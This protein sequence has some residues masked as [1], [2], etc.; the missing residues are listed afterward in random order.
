VV[1][2]DHDDPQA[3]AVR[4]GDGGGRLRA[5][6]VD[7]ADHPGEHQLPLQGLLGGR[8][9]GGLEGPVGDGQGA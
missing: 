3:G 5:G 6:R 9:L 1:A 2:G 8:R 7:D 4:L